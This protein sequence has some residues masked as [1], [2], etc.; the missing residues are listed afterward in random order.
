MTT[1]AARAIADVSEGTIL[2]TVDIAAP[3][4]RVYRALTTPEELVR[5]WGSDTM[6]RTTAWTADVRKGGRWTAEGKG[7]DGHTFSVEGEY[8]EVDPPNRL[9]QTWKPDWDGGHVT[10]IA[11]RLTATPQ[12]TRVT[13]RHTGFGDRAQSCEMHAAGWENVLGWLG[14]HFV[15]LPPAHRYFMVRLLA[16]RPTFPMDMT[17][18]EAAVMREHAGYWRRHLDEGK[19][20]VFGPVADP[21]GPWGL[22]VLRVEKEEEVRAFEAGDPAIVSGR[23]FRYE[24]LPMMQAVHR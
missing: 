22:G 18:E 19:A 16:P 9:V 7:S 4:E 14:L 6:Y 8:L 15:P 12:G 24:V 21:S 2:A 13:V 10:T 3:V 23:G 20:I 1:A 17:P 5:W 11:Y